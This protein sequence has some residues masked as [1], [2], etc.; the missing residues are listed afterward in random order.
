MEA[1]LVDFLP[2]L[3][4]YMCFWVVQLNFV[5]WVFLGHREV[6]DYSRKKDHAVL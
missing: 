3:R 2:M 1:N 5:S 4:D 6:K